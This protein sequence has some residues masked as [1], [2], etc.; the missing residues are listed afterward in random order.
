MTM[1][2]SWPEKR[3]RNI[4]VGITYG[5]VSA[6][7]EEDYRYLRSFWRELGETL[8]KIEKEFIELPPQK[9]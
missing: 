7:V 3:S 9:G 8:D 5:P 2:V 6:S 1:T 4:K